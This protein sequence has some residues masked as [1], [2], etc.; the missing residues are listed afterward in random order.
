MQAG[1][2]TIATDQWIGGNNKKQ[3]RMDWGEKDLVVVVLS[4]STA[5]YSRTTER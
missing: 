3:K 4:T 2:Q 5:R 1:I